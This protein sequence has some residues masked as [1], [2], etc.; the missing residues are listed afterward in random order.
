MCV[1]YPCRLPLA[2]INSL[3]LRTKLCSSLNIDAASIRDYFIIYANKIM[4]FLSNNLIKLLNRAVRK[5][6][7]DAFIPRQ[8]ENDIITYICIICI[9]IYVHMHVLLFVIIYII[10]YFVWNTKIYIV[11]MSE[12]VSSITLALTISWSKSKREKMGICSRTQDSSQTVR[13]SLSENNINTY[14]YIVACLTLSLSEYCRLEIEIHL[15][16]EY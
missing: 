14:V 2:R 10:I 3:E 1:S 8:N 15:S 11:C 6:K 7:L 16:F 4:L 9:Y 12:K 5:L 13:T